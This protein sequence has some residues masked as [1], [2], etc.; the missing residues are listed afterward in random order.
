MRMLLNSSNVVLVFLIIGGPTHTH[1]YVYVY[2]PLVE[3]QKD[4]SRIIY[5]SLSFY[6]TE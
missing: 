2:V 6:D 4:T 3:V 5:A 1:T